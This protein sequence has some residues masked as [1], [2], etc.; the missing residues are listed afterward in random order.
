VSRCPQVLSAPA[1][2]FGVLLPA[3]SGGPQPARLSRCGPLSVYIIPWYHPWCQ[4]L[5]RFVVGI[6]VITPRHRTVT[7][8]ARC[9]H[10]RA[11]GSPTAGRYYIAGG[12][13]VDDTW[14]TITEAAEQIPRD[15]RT[16]RRWCAKGGPLHT[17]ALRDTEGQWRIPQLWIDEWLAANSRPGETVP[18]TQQYASVVELLRAEIAAAVRSEIDALRRE[19]AAAR[20]ET[21]RSE[22]GR[23][24][25]L[26]AA[27]RALQEARRPWW[28]RIFRR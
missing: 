7:G 1:A 21:R 2:P 14:R 18:A 24:L 25:Q 12:G 9:G 11:G 16:L 23:D 8:H 20:D 19:L 26:L 3:S 22:E 17:V 28:R 27:I 5:F 6:E 10:A 15:E 13:A 4:P